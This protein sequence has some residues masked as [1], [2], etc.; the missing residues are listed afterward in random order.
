MKLTA[1]NSELDCIGRVGALPSDDASLRTASF[2]I[3][4]ALRQWLRE[5]RLPATMHSTR[6]GLSSA[7][8]IGT[9]YR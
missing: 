2:L 7:N 8:S 5:R 9:I 4:A 6:T 3:F 1:G